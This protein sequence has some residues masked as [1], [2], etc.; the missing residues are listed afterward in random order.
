M[1]SMEGGKRDAMDE[2]SA[3]VDLDAWGW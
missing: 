2:E 3:W 1:E